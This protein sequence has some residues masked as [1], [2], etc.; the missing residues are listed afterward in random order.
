M[1]ALAT[2]AVVAGGVTACGSIEPVAP[3]A[4]AT[5]P[6]A[7]PPS[8]PD[9]APGTCDPRALVDDDFE[10]GFGLGLRTDVQ[11]SG[12]DLRLAPTATSGEFRS[13][14]FDGTD[15]ATSWS[16]LSWTPRAPYGKALPGN[17][18]FE[19]DYAEDGIDMDDNVMLLHLDDADLSAGA[20][21][22]DDSGYENHAVI[23]GADMT[24][25]AGRFGQAVS[26]SSASYLYV[27]AA[28]TTNFDFG[29]D[30]LT[31][32]LWLNTQ[33]DCAAENQVYMGGE[34]SGSDGFHM[35]LGCRSS[36][37]QVCPAGSSGARA[38]GTFRSLQSVP[39]GAS[40][41]G[42]SRIDDGAW[43]HL[44]V[45][46]DGHADATVT[47]YVDGVAEAQLDASF[48]AP[49]DFQDN[50]DLNVGAFIDGSFQAEATLDE[51]AIWRRPLS[52]EEIASLYRRGV[53]RLEFEVRGCDD[54]QCQGAPDFPA[55]DALD[56][57]PLTD[58]GDALSAGSAI[59]LGG[60][61]RGRYFQYRAVFR[62]AVPGD[63]PILEEVS[64]RRA[65]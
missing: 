60:E 39:D 50:V 21:V 58:P 28:G 15:P 40:Y 22:R 47:L 36:A 55:A 18:G 2:V 19:G 10:C 63:G 49:I 53:R 30:D 29:E 6:D 57:N 52:A 35:W 33:Q 27:D 51:V 37:S 62:S 12:S 17:E 48:A 38:G 64:V 41:C 44:A 13:R 20:T 3:D 45:V 25:T 16:A 26:D 61:I 34:V 4:G 14:I 7:Q 23:A 59:D 11:W 1:T 32:A 54:A 43:H 56:R 9:A 24:A 8:P 5:A 42:T 65:Q 31:W 46:K